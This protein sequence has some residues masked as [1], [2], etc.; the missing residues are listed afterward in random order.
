MPAGFAVVGFNDFEFARYIDPPLTTVAS[1]GYEMGLRAAEML[2][3]YFKAGRFATAEVAFP[4]RLV[5]RASA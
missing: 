4:A 1:P 3:D 5:Q 2:L